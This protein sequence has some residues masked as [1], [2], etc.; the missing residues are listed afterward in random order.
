MVK[1]AADLAEAE[2]GVSVEVVDLGKLTKLRFLIK[3]SSLIEK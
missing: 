1:E 3:L 2:L